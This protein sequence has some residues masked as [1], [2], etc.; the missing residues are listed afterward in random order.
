MPWRSNDLLIRR[1]I[2]GHESR[3]ALFGSLVAFG[4][5]EAVFFLKMRK[6]LYLLATGLGL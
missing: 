1:F 4:E 3:I 6:N 5:L 2:V